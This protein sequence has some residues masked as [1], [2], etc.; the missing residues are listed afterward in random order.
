[1]K[2]KILAKLKE[3]YKSLGF[4]DK[5]I[6]AVASYLEQSVKEESQI[7]ESV[8]A[9]EPVLKA[10]QSDADRRVTDAVKAAEKKGGQTDPAKPEGGD[11]KKEEP[12]TPPADTPDWAKNLLTQFSALTQEVTAL[13]SGKT[14]DTRKQ[15]L[16]TALKD[17]TDTFKTMTLKA[18]NRMKFESDDEFNEYLEE[19]K[20]D[21]ANA[22]QAEADNGLGKMGKPIVPGGGDPNKPASKEE[23][24]SVVNK[25][26]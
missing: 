18:F 3:K 21:A 15:A 16:E 9:A 10:F 23:V 8:N 12:P 26:M 6:D 1:M 25:I 20:T 4:S 19:V 13:K 7:D 5:A 22:K 2:D 14:A 11:P 17:S 24:D